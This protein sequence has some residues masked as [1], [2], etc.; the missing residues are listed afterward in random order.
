MLLK[1]RVSPV[2][3]KSP[4]SSNR[5]K[6]IY[7]D[8]NKRAH[9]FLH[10]FLFCNQLS[11]VFFGKCVFVYFSWIS[12]CSKFCDRKKI[13]RTW[14][15]VLKLL[16]VVLTK[17]LD[18]Y[19]WLKEHIILLLLLFMSIVCKR[20]AHILCLCSKSLIDFNIWYWHF[21]SS[22]LLVFRPFQL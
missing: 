13:E 15:I 17:S 9:T 1:F 21:N 11:L 14:K 4:L 10:L 12:L 18:D 22:T 7:K 2:K 8:S 5:I 19:W 6:I 20:T 16:H 3:V